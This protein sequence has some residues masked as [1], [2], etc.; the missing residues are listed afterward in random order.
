MTMHPLLTRLLRRAGATVDAPPSPEVWRELLALV[1]RT[2]H[3]ADQDRYTLE[4]SIE[5]SSRE[6]HGLYED[7]KRNSESEI[8]IQRRALL[9]SYALLRATLAP[10]TAGTYTVIWRVLSVDSHVTQGRFT[11]R[12]E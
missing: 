12:V 6:L 5:I 10:L 2:Y 11:F 9:E 1:S 8:A 7:L 3:E 4:R